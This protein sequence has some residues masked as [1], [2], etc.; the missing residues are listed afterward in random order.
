MTMYQTEAEYLKNYNIHNYDVPLISVDIAV[1]TL[2]EGKLHL[3][4]IER[5]EHPH[6][7]RWALPGGF[8]DQKLDKDLEATAL[9]K[10]VEKTGVKAPHLEQIVSVGSS[11]RDPRGW[12]VTVL[13]MALI[14]F[15]PT[16]AFVDSVVDARWWPYKAALKQPLAFDHHELMQ[17]ARER[18]KRKTA[19]T[20]LP[21]HV[22]SAPFTLTQLQQAF[23]ELMDKVLEKKSFRRRI[24]TA[25]LLDEVG[26]GLPEGGRGRMAALYRPKKGNR[27][28][29]FIRVFGASE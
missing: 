3:L 4:M 18:L 1:F 25:D 19:Y 28:H 17:Q 12:S 21:I 24:L 26:E 8:I 7:G 23:E 13:Y 16:E 6:K 11:T 15:A 14:P 27:D 20:V 22:L 2:I 29:A 5:G 10:L 9:R